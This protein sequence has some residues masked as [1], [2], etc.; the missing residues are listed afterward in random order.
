MATQ[1]KKRSFF[2]SIKSKL[3]AMSV[4]PLLFACII[5]IITAFLSME[6]GLQS[7][8][9]DRLRD[10]CISVRASYDNLNGEPYTLND[11][12]DLMK[13]D[14]N[15][16]ENSAQMDSYVEGTDSEVTL[17]FGDTRKATT[18]LDA[19][20]G[21][22]IVGT[23]AAEAVSKRVLDGGEY[24]AL[25]LVINGSNY[26]AYYIPLTNPDGSVVGMVFAGAPSRE[27]QQFISSRTGILTGVALVVIALAFLLILFVSH[28]FTKAIESANL[29]VANLAAGD[30]TYEV[31]SRTLKRND[32]FGDMA[33]NVKNCIAE[34][35]TIVSNIQ[36][37]TNEVLDSG[38]ALENMAVSTSGNADNI[39]STIN[40]LSKG[41]VSLAED[42]ESA[43]LKISEMGDLI[44]NIVENIENLND[45]SANM[46]NAST[47]VMGIMQALD[48]S[49]NQTAE[50]IYNVAKN[51][52]ATDESVN[53]ISEAVELI[54]GVTSQTNLLSLNASIEAARAGEAG[55]GFAVVASEIQKLSDES[56]SSAQHISEIIN[57]LAMDSKNSMKMVEDVKE[58]LKEQQDKLNAT[59]NQVGNVNDGIVTANEGTAS[60]NGRAQDCNYARTDIMDIIQNLSAI[61]EEN[62]A[63]AEETAAS[64]QALNET[65]NLVADSSVKLKDLA[66]SLD[67]S[68]KF[69]KLK[70]Q[71]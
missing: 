20:T 13:G 18:L 8:V 70:Q 38:E 27:I 17:F 28:R 54:M 12:G 26:Y 64:M 11:N 21:E 44:G 14:V 48:V 19:A 4:I 41:A 61:S 31:D 45:T 55:K 32:E 68:T 10:I 71:Q 6:S 25:S 1:T 35:N 40:G 65:I 62:A 9:L 52:A 46:Q 7:A 56:N 69:F 66:S 49:N 22:R 63:S 5:I 43:T 57:N 50:A 3:V 51:V 2:H 39:T 34:L 59:K 36:T 16:T 42:I 58:R 29:A 47:E 15:I 30:L 37:Y 33:V 53:R 24:S 23:T 60:I 67:E